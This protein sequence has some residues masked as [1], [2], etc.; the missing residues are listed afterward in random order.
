MVMLRIQKCS[1]G[2][3]FIL[4]SGQGLFSEWCFFGFEFHF[5]FFKCF[6]NF[7]NHYRH[8]KL[9]S[10]SATRIESDTG[11]SSRKTRFSL[12]EMCMN[13]IQLQE[14]T[15]TK[16]SW[17]S[18]MAKPDSLNPAVEW[19]KIT[20]HRVHPTNLVKFECICIDKW[21]KTELCKSRRHTEDDSDSVCLSFWRTEHL[22]IRI[23]IFNHKCIEFIRS[24]I[25]PWCP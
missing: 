14:I 11:R 22:W 19:A 10:S 21:A 1:P 12:P 8:T 16:E 17:Y 13:T 4:K 20:V 2:H 18:A 3:Y 15:W 6:T 5:F 24:L 7:P 23:Y 25:Q 9:K